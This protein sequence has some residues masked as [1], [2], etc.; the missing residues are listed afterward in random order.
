M[1]LLL[2]DTTSDRK[3]S[4]HPQETATTQKWSHIDHHRASQSLTLK[5]K[6][7]TLITEVPQKLLDFCLR[8]LF[9]GSSFAKSQLQS[10]TA[11]GRCK[12]TA[13]GISFHSV[14]FGNLI[15]LGTN[16]SSPALRVSSLQEFLDQ[17]MF[18]FRVFQ[19]MGGQLQQWGISAVIQ[20]S[21][22]SRS[23]S[24]VSASIHWC[25]LLSITLQQSSQTGTQNGSGTS[26]RLA[27]R[28]LCSIFSSS[29]T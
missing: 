13:M 26:I 10:R 2:W 18:Y 4:W 24:H 20:T 16:F 25:A 19:S 29:Q 8:K 22:S 1:V 27:V 23:Q 11:F 9:S 7:P 5:R 28:V 3:T 12:K 17:R 15:R 21:Y 14:E 6:H